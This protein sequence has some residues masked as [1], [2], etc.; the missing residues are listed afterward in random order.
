MFWVAQTEQKR[1]GGVWGRS[2]WKKMLA[3]ALGRDV[4]EREGGE[5]WRVKTE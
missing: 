3:V 4:Q 5:W 1:G 2:K